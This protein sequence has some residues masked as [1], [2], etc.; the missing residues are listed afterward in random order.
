MLKHAPE[1]I[2]RKI[3]WKWIL[4]L[5]TK[6][7]HKQVRTQKMKISTSACTC[8]RLHISTSNSCNVQGARKWA[9]RE[10]Y[11]L[12]E[13][14]WDHRKEPELSNSILQSKAVERSGN[15]EVSDQW[16]FWIRT[17]LQ[18]III[19]Y[20]FKIF[21][22]FPS[23]CIGHLQKN[24][25]TK[26]FFVVFVLL[27]FVVTIAILW[28]VSYIFM[29]WLGKFPSFSIRI[30]IKELGL[31]KRTTKTSLFLTVF[32]LVSNVGILFCKYCHMARSEGWFIIYNDYVLLLEKE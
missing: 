6:S 32:F 15:R 14:M 7:S 28:I 11:L 8:W 10:E 18:I 16:S 29:S 12:W 23:P 24:T 26:W 9:K 19:S 13:E 4:N 3:K 30:K 2:F 5:Q 1:E 25:S 27:F 21:L 22:M 17:R 20:S 31:T